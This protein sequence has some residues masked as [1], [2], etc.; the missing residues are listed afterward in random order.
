MRGY[1]PRARMTLSLNGVT[2]SSSSSSSSPSSAPQHGMKNSR[3]SAMPIP[4]TTF[5]T[6]PPA[7][8]PASLQPIALP[9]PF[10]EAS[11]THLRYPRQGQ[12]LLKT[13]QKKSRTFTIRSNRQHP[14]KL[15]RKI[16][17]FVCACGASFGQRSHLTAHISTVHYQEGDYKWEICDFRFGAKSDLNSHIAAAHYRIK[18]FEC[19]VSQCRFAKSS[20]LKKHLLTVRHLK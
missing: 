12:P 19:G 18:K 16:K 15:P 6:P 14:P 3:A 13:I 20:D 7:A 5:Y 9:R 2:I 17:P 1:R 8:P 11:T 4:A 10:S